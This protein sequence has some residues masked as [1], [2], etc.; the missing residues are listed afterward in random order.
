MDAK[1]SLH[2]K[3]ADFPSHRQKLFIDFRGGSGTLLKD[4]RTL[5]SYPSVKSGSTI[6]IV[7]DNPWKLYVQDP[8]GKIYDIE[9][10]SNEPLVCTYTYAPINANPHYPPPGQYQGTVGR[11]EAPGVGDLTNLDREILGDY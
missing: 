7:I 8:H 5:S 11:F 10:P 1:R 2:A 9:I 3:R 4:D 6:V